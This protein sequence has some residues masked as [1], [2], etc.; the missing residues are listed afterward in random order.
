MGKRVAGSL[1]DQASRFGSEETLGNLP[2]GTDFRQMLSEEGRE[3]FP[4]KGI[5]YLLLVPEAARQ[6]SCTSGTSGSGPGESRSP[7]PSYYPNPWLSLLC[8]N[9]LA[10]S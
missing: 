4:S 8:S 6:I 3:V 1:G 7:E 5:R 10:F 2:A 9:P